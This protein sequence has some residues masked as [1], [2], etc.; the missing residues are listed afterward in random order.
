MKLGRLFLCFEKDCEEVF[1]R[2]PRG[3]CPACGSENIHPLAW[4]LRERD[5]RQEWIGRIWRVKA[6]RERLERSRV[7]TE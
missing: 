2:A 6:V 3:K 7:A 1:E 4:Q 5:E